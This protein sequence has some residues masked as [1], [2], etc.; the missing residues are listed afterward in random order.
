[1]SQWEYCAVVGIFNS[2]Q[3]RHLSPKFPA[4]WY[5]APGGIQIDEI[6]SK[7]VQ[8]VTQT[9]ARL[10]EEGWEMVGCGNLEVAEHAI[11]FKRRRPQDSTDPSRDNGHVGD[12][13]VA[14]S[15]RLG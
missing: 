15:A 11:Y 6:K 5:F 12:T 13:E 2:F 10:G 9:I 14:G 8:A 3:N 1:M 4:V 7:D